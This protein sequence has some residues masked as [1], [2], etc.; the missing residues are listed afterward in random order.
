MSEF[1][2]NI[3]KQEADY[4]NVQGLL[5]RIKKLEQELAEAKKDQ[6]RWR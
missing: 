4:T 3:P 2:P 1:V 6:A 5:N